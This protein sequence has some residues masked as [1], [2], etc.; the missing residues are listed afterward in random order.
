[1]KK[2]I[3]SLCV[4]MLS[5]LLTIRNWDITSITSKK[6]AKS[7]RFLCVKE[8]THM[9]FVI[10]KYHLYRFQAGVSIKANTRNNL[11]QYDEL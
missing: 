6:K 9:V 5:N 4:H 1:M 2:D 8:C 10:V 7:I 3:V 11:T